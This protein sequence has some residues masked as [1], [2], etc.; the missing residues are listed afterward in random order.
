MPR[1]DYE[2]QGLDR[3]GF[4]KA[5]ALTAV[6]A[7]ATGT[8]AALLFDLEKAS[9]PIITSVDALPPATTIQTAVQPGADSSELMARLAAA[10]AENLQLKSQLGAVQRQLEASQNLTG[11]NPADEAAQIQ[12]EEAN[13]QISHLSGQVGVLGGLVALYEQLEGVDLGAAAS[14][15]IASV[16]GA[17]D[18][19]FQNVPSVE[20]GLL[21]GQQALAE[22]EAQVPLVD[23]G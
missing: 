21:A 22:F 23:N 5:A 12:L 17:L 2:E 7:T 8:G 10:Q 20:E 14:N 19:L 9:P 16:S 1:D 4:L 6:A 15:G 11:A 13:A 18:D 3:R